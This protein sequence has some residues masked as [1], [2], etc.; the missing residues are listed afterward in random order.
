MLCPLGVLA[1]CLD[2]ET[3]IGLRVVEAQNRRTVAVDNAVERHVAHLVALPL[4]MM[5]LPAAEPEIVR[6]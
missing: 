1:H 2:E 5:V 4:R 3:Q 6:A